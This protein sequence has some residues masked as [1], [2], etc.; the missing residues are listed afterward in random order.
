MS[1]GNVI[2]NYSGH[3]NTIEDVQWSPN[4]TRIASAS[5]DGTVQV[6]DATTGGNPYTYTGHTGLVW[7]L[8]WSANGQSIASAAAD[9]TVRV[10]QA[11]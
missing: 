1:T 8:A 4:G 9:N 3:S 7:A 2:N 10:W 6:W 5:K 11:S